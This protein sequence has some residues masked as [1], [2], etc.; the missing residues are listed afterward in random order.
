[1]Q[2]NPHACQQSARGLFSRADFIFHIILSFYL[3]IKPEM[4][5]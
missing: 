4:M 1:M 3:I 2:E 5:I